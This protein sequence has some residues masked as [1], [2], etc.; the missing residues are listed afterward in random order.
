MTRDELLE[1]ER[2]A[3]L[4]PREMETAAPRLAER[5]RPR[6]EA[7]ANAAVERLVAAGS[8]RLREVARDLRVPLTAREEGGRLSEAVLGGIRAR[9]REDTTLRDD[10]SVRAELEALEHALEGGRPTTPTP[11]SRT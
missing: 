11:G 3:H 4:T 5:V 8:P 9:V 1:L 6:L 10:A 2:N 7:R